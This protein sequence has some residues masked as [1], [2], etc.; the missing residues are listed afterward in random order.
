M[1]ECVICSAKNHIN[2]DVESCPKNNMDFEYYCKSC[3]QPT[4][5][6]RVVTRKM[7]AELNRIKME[8]ELKQSIVDKCAEHGLVCRFVY[9]SVI[10]T[11]PLADWCFDYHQSRKTLYHES[12]T[13]INF[14]TGDYCKAHCQFRNRKMK[15]SEIIDYIVNHDKWRAKHQFHKRYMYE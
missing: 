14:E 8:R 13:K 6:R 10:I 4:N 7:Q 15:I 1:C 11:T 3:G 12:T 9:Q 2:F 5:H